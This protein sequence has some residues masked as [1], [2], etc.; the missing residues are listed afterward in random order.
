MCITG[1]DDLLALPGKGIERVKEFF[2]RGCL[3]RKEMYVINDEN[4]NI[5]ELAPECFHSPC[6]ETQDELICET[7]PAYHDAPGA[8]A[9]SDGTVNT[10]QK[11][12]LPQPHGTVDEQ[13]VVRG[14][15]LF[16]NLATRNVS[17]FVAGANYKTIQLLG[18]SPLAHWPGRAAPTDNA[19]VTL[20]LAC[21]IL[22]EESRVYLETDS[23][24]AAVRLFNRS[25]DC[26]SKVLLKPVNNK[27]AWHSYSCVILS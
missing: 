26:F 23:K 5:S 12:R 8:P 3:A 24:P 15:D 14:Y 16:G 1:N 4:V 18:R 11:M 9:P 25:H 7:F 19:L 10:L 6:P 27:S 13:R 17:Y 22:A 21:T 2:L 20:L